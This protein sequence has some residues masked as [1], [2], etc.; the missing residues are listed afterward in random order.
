MMAPPRWLQRRNRVLQ[1]GGDA[2]DI[3]GEDAVPFRQIE[4]L[5]LAPGRHQP[6]IGD[7]DVEPAEALDRRGERGGE[8]RLVGDVGGQR[9]EA[10]WRLGAP[11]RQAPGRPPR[12]SRRR[13]RR[14]RRWPARGRGSPPSPAPRDPP[15]GP[16]SPSPR[17]RHIGRLTPPPSLTI[18]RPVKA[19]LPHRGRGMPSEARRVRVFPA[20]GDLVET[21]TLPALPARPDPL[22][23]CGRGACC[24]V[25]RPGDDRLR[26]PRDRGA[27][28]RERRCGA[29]R[30]R[31]P[32]PAHHAQRGGAR[33][34]LRHGRVPGLPGRDRRQAR[35]PGLHDDDRRAAD[36]PPRGASAPAG[37]G[38]GRASPR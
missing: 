29:D 38:R 37:A 36:G 35:P 4:R 17:R 24:C 16:P 32:W 10:G 19:P 15:A 18:I 28:G 1:G 26:G 3:D 31:R 14:R 21:L 5:G 34:L 6:G 2:A 13:R 30:G 7:D 22:P 9:G 23:R 27:P 11:R 12:P 20:M 25:M 8:R 33:H